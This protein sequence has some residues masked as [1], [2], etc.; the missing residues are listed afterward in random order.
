[1]EQKKE[2]AKQ[3]KREYSDEEEEES[4]DTGMNLSK[5]DAFILLKAGEMSQKE[6]AE[7]VNERFDDVEIGRRRVGQ[8]ISNHD[9]KIA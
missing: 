4:G 2:D 6:I 9:A 1:M 5:R 7:A 3:G 8:V